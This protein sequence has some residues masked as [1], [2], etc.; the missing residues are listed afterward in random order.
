MAL[1]LSRMITGLPILSLALV[2]RF[3]RHRVCARHAAWREMRNDIFQLSNN[4]PATVYS[5]TV[6]T[7]H[8]WV[9]L[10]TIRR[11]GV[12]IA[13]QQTLWRCLANAGLGRQL[14]GS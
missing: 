10:L 11:G 7:M 4:A 9:R 14:P 13:Y 3:F 8:L 12:H 5:W 1:K 6:G 2:D